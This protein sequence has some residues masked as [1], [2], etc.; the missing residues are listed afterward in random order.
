M[1]WEGRVRVGRVSGGAL[2]CGEVDQ[3]HLDLEVFRAPAGS[4]VDCLP[5]ARSAIKGDAY[6]LIEQLPI[7]HIM[8]RLLDFWDEQL[9]VRDCCEAIAAAF[10]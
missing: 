8:L 6:V 3:A 5:Q 7:E 1:F 9:H 10:K 2:E 4:G